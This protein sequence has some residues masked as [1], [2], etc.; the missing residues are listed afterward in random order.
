MEGAVRTPLTSKV[1]NVVHLIAL[2]NVQPA[3]KRDLPAR[4]DHNA[5]G[6]N[7]LRLVELPC[8]FN[9]DATA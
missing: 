3:I 7:G 9:A 8:E 5:S 2:E 4:V 6:V 1:E